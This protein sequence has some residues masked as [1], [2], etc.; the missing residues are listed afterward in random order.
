VSD[1]IYNIIYDKMCVLFFSTYFVRA[2]L[3]LRRNERD[4]IKIC[5]GLHV[6]YSLILSDLNETLNFRTDF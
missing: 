2:F 4:M 6:K 5:I 1:G 3:I